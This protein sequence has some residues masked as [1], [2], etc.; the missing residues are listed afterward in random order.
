MR[1]Y[2]LDQTKFYFSFILIKLF[3]AVSTNFIPFAIKRKG[4]IIVEPY[5][6]ALCV[7]FVIFR[8]I[9]EKSVTE[10]HALF[11]F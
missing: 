2:R 9:S 10:L 4:M 6:N 5:E 8:K 11:I 7:C 1:K 3:Q